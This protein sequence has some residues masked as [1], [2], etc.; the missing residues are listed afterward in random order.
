[1]RSSNCSLARYFT[2]VYLRKGAGNHRDEE[3]VSDDVQEQAPPN[4]LVSAGMF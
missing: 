1:M 2:P 4:I 3:L